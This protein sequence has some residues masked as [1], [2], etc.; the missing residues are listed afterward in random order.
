MG[1]KVRDHRS[2][3][4]IVI[5]S[6]PRMIT[7]SRAELPSGINGYY[8]TWTRLGLFITRRGASI[9]ALCGTMIRPRRRRDSDCPK[10]I[11]DIPPGG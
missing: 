2:I 10:R 3:L 7:S 5:V 6:T 8:V 9:S 4:H 1:P 11:D